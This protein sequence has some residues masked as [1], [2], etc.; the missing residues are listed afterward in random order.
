MI[1]YFGASLDFLFQTFLHET[2]VHEIYA[3]S[4]IVEKTVIKQSQHHYTHYTE[5][6]YG[7]IVIMDKISKL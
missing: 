4:N 2:F 1:Y 5:E 6:K 3:N 7:I